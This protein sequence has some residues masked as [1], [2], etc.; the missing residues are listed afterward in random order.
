[1]SYSSLIFND[2]PLCVWSLEEPNGSVSVS[3][4]TFINDATK[5]GEYNTSKVF[6]SSVPI[7]YAGSFSVQNL[8]SFDDENIDYETDN[9]L[10]TVPSQDIFSSKT[11]ARQFS[12]EFWMNLEID[13]T[14]ISSSLSARIGE[15]EIV[16]FSGNTNT[17]L[18]IRD[19]DY[20]V[21]KLGDT[22]KQIYESCIHVPD[23]NSPLHIGIVYNQNSIQ[24]FVNGEAGSEG[25]IDTDP[26]VDHEERNIEFRFPAKISESSENFLNVNY[27]T[28]AIYDQVLL[29]STL[30]RHYVYGVGKDVPREIFSSLGGIVY[31]SN[32]QRTLPQKQITYL[33][34]IN[35]TS[36]VVLNNLIATNDNLS[37]VRFPRPRLIIKDPINNDKT[38]KDMIQEDAIVF[39]EDCFSYLEISN[40][41]SITEGATKKVEAKFEID[42]THGTDSQVLLHVGSLSNPSVYLSFKIEDRDISLIVSDEV[43]GT[44]TLS[45]LSNSFFVSYYVSSGTVYAS[46][47][48]DLDGF[49]DISFSAFNIFPMQNAYLRFGSEP[50]FFLENIDQNT[51]TDEV[52]RFDGRLLQVDIYNNLSKTDSWADY[53]EL[54]SGVSLYQM[55]ANSLV[56]K[57]SVATK[58]SFS[59]TISLANLLKSSDFSKNI[60][61]VKL[62]TKVV[63]GSQAS[64]IKYDFIKVT[65]GVETTLDSQEDIRML[66][67]PDI[68]TNIPPVIDTQYRIVGELFSTDSDVTP[69]ILDYLSITSYPVILDSLKSYIDI[70]SDNSGSNLRYYSGITP[71]NINYPFK[72]LPDIDQTTDLYRSFN[73]GF[74][75]GSFHNT[76]PYIQ[77]PIDT[78]SIGSAEKI[79]CV[80]FTGILKSGLASGMALANLGGVDVSWATP[81]PSGVELYINGVRYS[82]SETYNQNAW[83]LYAIKFTSGINIPDDLKI[84]F[85][86]SSNWIADNISVFTSDI[87]PLNIGKIYKEYFGTVPVKVVDGY[88]ES[89]FGVIPEGALTQETT[90]DGGG[91]LTYTPTST[92][93][94]GASI[95]DFTGSIDG[96]IALQ[97]TSVIILDSELSNGQTMFQPLIGQSGFYAISLC[98]RLASTSDSGNWVLSGTSPNFIYT[99]GANRDNQKVDNIEP[100]LNDLIL[101]KNQTTTSQNG[102][103]KVTGKTTTSL[104]LVK[105]ANPVVN[106]L[107]FVRDGFINKNYYF[108]RTS[109]N[110]Y[111]NSVVQRKVGSYDKNGHRAMITIPVVQ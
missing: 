58:G 35:W 3:C 101:L 5:N 83:N 6:M 86:S 17:G 28:V 93:D 97:K 64:N 72:D 61:E 96:Q 81:E 49:E 22:G 102:I 24:I 110:T 42:G 98:P 106:N 91:S 16:T 45:S 75:V 12:L 84:G 41:E 79:Y 77:V 20:L 108:K 105:Q 4:D 54:K 107:I 27:D 32:M 52:E 25:F 13:P 34:N 100:D 63:V 66:N 29:P 19:L 1:M 11:K 88:P 69:G 60:N 90:V 23:F 99:F 59:L 39:P 62:A 65:G 37:T 53:P 47:R 76:N 21:F 50:K 14:S 95:V 57:I 31:G 92:V 56:K 36:N 40:Y 10:F 109:S 67:L 87:S 68:D 82:G 70:N 51:S 18:Y 55:Y 111:V 38:F 46:I 33:N 74:C 43:K 44:Y 80:I 89:F 9:I 15:S 2:A 7:T 26:F 78:S 94:G 8:G 103:Y 73:T 71:S 85:N 104:T 48:D 30:K